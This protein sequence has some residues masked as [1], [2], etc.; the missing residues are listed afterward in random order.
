[1]DIGMLVLWNKLLKAE[2]KG[3]YWAGLTCLRLQWW[4][5]RGSSSRNCYFRNSQHKRSHLKKVTE[6]RLVPTPPGNIAYITLLQRN[7]LSITYS[8]EDQT[9]SLFKFLCSQH[10]TVH[11]SMISMRYL[12][13][14]VAKSGMVAHTYVIPAFEKLKDRGSGIQCNTQL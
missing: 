1:M 4:A 5:I 8:Q 14:Q 13:V 2:P 11:N 3:D 9:H 7:S 10:C 6:S 12:K